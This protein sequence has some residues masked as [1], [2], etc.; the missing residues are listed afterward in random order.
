[1]YDRDERK[2]IQVCVSDTA[3]SVNIYSAEEFPLVGLSGADAAQCL[4]FRD[5]D[6]T[7]RMTLMSHES[8]VGFAMN[9][10]EGSHGSAG[11]SVD[12][13]SARLSVFHGHSKAG[14]S[15]SADAQGSGV[16]VRDGGGRVRWQS[17]G[18]VRRVRGNGG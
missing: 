16:F 7:T 1:M 17:P 18:V 8:A 15:M 4:I 13:D 14:A 2:R 11:M 3:G 9:E 12:S 10:A 6:N 5:G